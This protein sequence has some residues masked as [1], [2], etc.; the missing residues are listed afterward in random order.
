M[1]R[2][3]HELNLQAA[4]V[5]FVAVVGLDHVRGRQ[6][7]DELRF[8]FVHDDFGFTLLEQLR[9]ACYLH[10]GKSKWLAAAPS[11]ELHERSIFCQL[12][13]SVT[14]RSSQDM[15]RSSAVTLPD[16]WLCT[17]AG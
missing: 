11:A 13:R 5:D 17:T 8:R 7:L 4:D 12:T 3:V 15:E 14:G 2:S 6:S 9:S 10:A 1:S 16:G